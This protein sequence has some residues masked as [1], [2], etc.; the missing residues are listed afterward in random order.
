MAE[1]RKQDIDLG[2]VRLEYGDTARVQ[3]AVLTI[4]TDKYYNGGVVSSATVYWVSSHSRQNC[5]S[6]GGDGGDYRRRL[7]VTSKEV[8]ATQKNIDLQHAQV[9]VEDV[10]AGL[11]MAAK[12]HYAEAVRT[13]I[14]GFSNTYPKQEVNL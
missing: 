12:A 4:D 9:F 3:R 2:I 6:L 11:V 8:R 7:R 14:D 10:V 5:M 1:G 13:G